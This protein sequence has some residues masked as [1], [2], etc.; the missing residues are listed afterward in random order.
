MSARSECERASNKLGWTVTIS[1]AASITRPINGH[2]HALL[3]PCEHSCITLIFNAAFTTVAGALK[4]GNTT[5]ITNAWSLV[6]TRDQPAAGVMYRSRDALKGSQGASGA[7]CAQALGHPSSTP[8]GQAG[9]LERCWPPD[10]PHVGRRGRD[11]SSRT[12]AKPSLG[13]AAPNGIY[14]IG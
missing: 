7:L 2:A 13:E 5:L 11:V 1:R 8:P 14:G 10:G 6:L 12:R 3:R 9:Q 4:S